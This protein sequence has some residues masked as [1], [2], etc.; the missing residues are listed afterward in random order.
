MALPRGVLGLGTNRFPDLHSIPAAFPTIGDNMAR[1][2]RLL[3]C[4]WAVAVC[5][6]F[7]APFARAGVAAPM[8]VGTS[9]VTLSYVQDGKEV[10]YSGL[11]NFTG[12]SPSA[13]TELDPASNVKVFQSANGFGRRLGVANMFPMVLG[14]H[15]TL[16]SHNFFKKVN[17]EEY[18]PGIAA[19]GV[20][21][22]RV[23]GIIFDEPV[24]VDENTAIFHTLW[25]PEQSRLLTPPYDHG[26]NIHTL[27]EDFRNEHEFHMAHEFHDGHYVLGDMSGR[28]EILGNGTNELTLMATVPYSLFMHLADEGN[29]V[30]GGLPAPHGFLEP[31]HFHFEYI[32]TAVPEPATLLMLGLG[33]VWA[34]RRRPG[35]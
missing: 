29:T 27:T 17:A 9:Q 2:L 34:I 31:F 24:L 28:L 4:V 11:R 10:E 13:A 21:T 20:V 32:V 15:E 19:D 7:L 6:A 26:H 3:A 16:M 25:D 18:F 30:P 23:D 8:P 5:F 12:T 22:I 1:F 14:D 33:S 35:N